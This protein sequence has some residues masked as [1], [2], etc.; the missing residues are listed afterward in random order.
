ME[1][2]TVHAERGW[3]HC[4]G[5]VLILPLPSIGWLLYCDWPVPELMWMVLSSPSHEDGF[6][7]VEASRETYMASGACSSC[8]GQWWH[9]RWCYGRCFID[10][11]VDG[12]GAAVSFTS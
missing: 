10:R 5:N 9:V 8:N 6:L 7:A 12:G 2:C 4:C 1:T 3:L 11:E